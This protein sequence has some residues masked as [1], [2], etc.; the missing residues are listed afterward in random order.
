MQKEVFP[1]H[2]LA[3]DEFNEEDYTKE[4]L[5]IIDRSKD[6]LWQD[7]QKNNEANLMVEGGASHIISS[8]LQ[9]LVPFEEFNKFIICDLDNHEKRMK[10][11]TLT[12]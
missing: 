6:A 11:H 7:Y 12:T 10:N 1:L 2:M 4:V 3:D 5:N 9:C 8:I